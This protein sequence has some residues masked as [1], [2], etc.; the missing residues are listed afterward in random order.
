MLLGLS[1][2]IVHPLLSSKFVLNFKEGW[3]EADCTVCVC[4]CVCV[5]MCDLIT[6]TLVRD[7]G[8][9]P[10]RAWRDKELQK[11]DQQPQKWNSPLPE[12][13]S[14]DSVTSTTVGS[15][16]SS[17]NFTASTEKVGQEREGKEGDRGRE[18]VRERERERERGGGGG[19]GRE[20]YGEEDVFMCLP[21]TG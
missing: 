8:K 4:V 5:C 9:Q 17:G 19:R 20:R 7:T 11:T 13:A 2:V 15:F 16:D 3:G 6:S 1:L 14:D 12:W 21:L 10:P 18:T